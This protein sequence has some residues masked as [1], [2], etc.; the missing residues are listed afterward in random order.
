[1][2]P[3]S[4]EQVIAGIVSFWHTLNVHTVNLQKFTKYINHLRE[5]KYS[6]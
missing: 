4:K 1:M 6:C 5:V 2:K 3:K